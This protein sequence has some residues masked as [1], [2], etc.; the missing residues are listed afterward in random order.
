MVMGTPNTTVMIVDLL[1]AVSGV[2]LLIGEL[3]KEEKVSMEAVLTTAS[4]S[5]RGTRKG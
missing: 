4:A 5:T 1:R 2:V 3:D